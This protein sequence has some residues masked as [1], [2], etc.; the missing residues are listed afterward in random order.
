MRD[1]DKAD[2]QS[3]WKTGIW[4]SQACVHF[5]SEDQRAQ[6]QR[7]WD[8]SALQAFET[9][10]KKVAPNAQ[11]VLDLITSGMNDMQPLILSRQKLATLL[12][13]QLLELL[14]DG[15]LI[16]FGFE[17]TRTLQSVPAPIPSEVWDGQT[18]FVRNSIHYQSIELLDV[19]VCHPNWL[20]QK[21]DIAGYSGRRS[22]RP[23][24]E[25]E[26]KECFEELRS[27][28][29][30]DHAVPMASHYPQIRM[31]LSE[32]YPEKFSSRRQLSD[33]GIRKY[34]SPYFKSLK[35]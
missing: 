20:P 30:L 27:N 2:F 23:S 5:A 10:Y 1:F 32:R 8:Q 11:S 26:L 33:E 24:M 35:G 28:G 31:W 12:Q 22:G 4:L 17:G 25:S 34:F 19:R 16:G 21:H 13:E 29:K 9:G 14:R 6:H 15:T 3:I 18:N 7:L